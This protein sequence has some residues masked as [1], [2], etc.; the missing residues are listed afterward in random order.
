MTFLPG[1]ARGPVGACDPTTAGA[2][3]VGS[4]TA[5]RP[6]AAPSPFPPDVGVSSMTEKNSVSRRGFLE[7]D[8][9]ATGAVAASGVFPHP[10]IGAVKG[11]NE[12]INFAILGPGGRAQE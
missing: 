10:A 5:G 1:R 6:P 2:G 4:G 7:T 12:K 8:G 3:P 9:L 11:A